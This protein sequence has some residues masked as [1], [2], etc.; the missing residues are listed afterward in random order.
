[1]AAS[2]DA[3]AASPARRLFLPLGG[4]LLVTL[5]IVSFLALENKPTLVEMK[6]AVQR[7]SFVTLPAVQAEEE[8]GTLQATRKIS[9][10]PAALGVQAMEVKD[11]DC[12]DTTLEGIGNVGLQTEPGGSI[13][14]KGSEAETLLPELVLNEPT[15]LRFEIAGRDKVTIWLEPSRLAQS[16]GARPAAASSGPASPCQEA[17]AEERGWNAFLPTGPDLL[18]RLRG[19]RET[20][21]AGVPL[22]ES[23]RVSGDAARFRVIGGRH[24]SRLSLAL[25]HPAGPSAV[26]RKLNPANGEVSPPTSLPIALSEPRIFPWQDGLVLLDPG[27]GGKRSVPLLRSDLK[28]RDLRLSRQVQLEEKSF[29]LEGEVRFPAGE[30]DAVKLEPGSFVSVG[31]DPD[32]PLTLRALE[33]ADQRLDML[34]WGEP[35]SLRIGPTPELRAE[36]LPSYFEWLHTHRLGGLIYSTLAYVSALSFAVFKLLGWVKG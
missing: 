33:L 4:I 6:V 3:P 13:G 25:P 32:R 27:P 35:T 10:F 16:P 15:S 29:V 18:L 19:V 9:L 8:E 2:S 11:V 21:R 1:M 31:T 28:V 36:R 5:L 24:D 22:A 12:V 7:V 23:Y 20:A 17:G 14:V 30:K 34:L 26:L